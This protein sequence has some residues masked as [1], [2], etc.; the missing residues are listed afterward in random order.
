MEKYWDHLKRLP[1]NYDKFKEKMDKKL[2]KK[3]KILIKSIEEVQKE[4][5]HF[6]V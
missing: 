3:D 5:E 1:L 2:L 4:K 6:L